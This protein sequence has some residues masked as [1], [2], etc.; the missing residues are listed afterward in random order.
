MT[1]YNWG[2]IGLGG[3]G[4]QFAAHLPKDQTLYGVAAHDPA[5]AAAF[6]KQY[7]AQHAFADYAALFADPKIDIVYVAT[8]HNFHYENI[9][10]ALTAGKH[11]LAEKAI[12]LNLTQLDELIALAAAKNLILMEA[13]TIYHMPLYPTLT[14]FAQRQQLGQL[15]TIDVTFGSYAKGKPNS[16]LYDP[17]LGGG[18]MLDIGV[19]ALSFARRFLSA[20]PKLVA[21]QW[22]PTTTGVDGQ[23]VLMLNNAN[24]EMVNVALNLEARMPKR[25][26]VAYSEGYFTVDQYPRSQEAIFT[27]PDQ[28]N[29]P[30]TADLTEDAL[31]Y[32][33][34]DMAEAVTTGVNPTLAWTRDVMAI[35]TEARTA[36]G[37]RYPNE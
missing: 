37:F 23:S 35:M 27:T 16:R 24:H 8:T 3:I 12:V 17:A 30:I 25:G 29:A 6:A 28:L 36:W 18:A 33:A 2:I 10:A 7:H 22:T 15:K 26:V 34:T 31:A 11:V 5:R 32:E 14:A 20:A 21:T 4:S 1:T 19:Y 13:Q 9:K